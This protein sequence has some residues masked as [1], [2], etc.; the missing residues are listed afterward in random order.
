LAGI[1]AKDV[2]ALRD[3]T[4][5]GMMDCKKALT[6]ASGEV[7]AA[8]VLLRERGLAKAGKRSGRETSEGSVGIA[9]DGG[10][11]TLVEIGCETDFVAR[12]DKFQALVQKIVDAIAAAGAGNSL[13]AALK[14]PCDGTTVEELIQSNVGVIGENIELKRVASLSVDGVVAGYIHGGGS[15]GVLVAIETA[16]PDA[17]AEVGREIAMHVAAADP[18]PLAVSRDDID[19]AVIEKEREFLTKQAL[20]SGKPE[21]IVENMVQGRLNKFYV[22]H[23][24]VDQP[25]VKDPDKKVGQIVSEAGEG[26]LSAFVRFKLGEAS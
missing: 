9:L 3:Q 6:D 1:S 24:L 25:F 22:E 5:A 14:A 2:K 26:K 17:F 13:E 19:P 18:T 12:N 16:S 23:A 21:N 15:L 20:D 4:G 11:G 8:I 7:E 10:Q